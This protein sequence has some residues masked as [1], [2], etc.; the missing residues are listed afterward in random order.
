[1]VGWVG[2]VGWGAAGVWLVGWLVGWLGG[3]GWGEGEGRFACSTIGREPR[4]RLSLESDPPACS[5]RFSRYG[6]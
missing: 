5:P 2:E 6:Q 3:W 1:M 4:T